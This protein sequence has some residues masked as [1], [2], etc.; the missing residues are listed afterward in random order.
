MFS[1]EFLVSFGTSGGTTTLCSVPLALLPLGRLGDT[2]ASRFGSQLF[3][4]QQTLLCLKELGLHLLELDRQ[5]SHSNGL[6]LSTG[7]G[8]ANPGCLFMG[9]WVP[10]PG[11]FLFLGFL[12]PI[13]VDSTPHT[14]LFLPHNAR[15]E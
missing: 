8:V 1:M 11:C 15:A 2:T 12:G 6:F 14:S 5:S 4:C 10:I 3:V 9:S 7:S 13:P